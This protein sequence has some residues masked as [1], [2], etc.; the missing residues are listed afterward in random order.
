GHVFNLG[1]GIL[2]DTPVESA[3][4]LVEFVHTLSRTGIEER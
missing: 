1:H 2:P 4:A 3:Q